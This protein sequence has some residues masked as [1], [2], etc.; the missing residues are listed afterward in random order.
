VE[1]VV[2]PT[3]APS[4]KPDFSLLT[5]LVAFYGVFNPEKLADQASVEKLATAYTDNEYDLNCALNDQYGNDLS[6]SPGAQ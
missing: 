6:D 2:R 3:F 4:N 1:Q 5:R